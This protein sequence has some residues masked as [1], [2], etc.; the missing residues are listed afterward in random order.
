MKPRFALDLSHDAVSLLERT[1]DG[2]VR[3]GNALLDAPSLGDQLGGMKALAHARAPEGFVSKLILPNTQILYFEM[4]APGEDQATRRARIEEAL[5]GRTPYA[6]EDLVY[7]FSRQG[8]HVK[9]AVVARETLEEAEGFAEAYGF[10]PAAFV[11]IPEASRFAGEP[12]FGLT[13][14]ANHYLPKDTRF[15][16][17]QDPARVIAQAVAPLAALFRALPGLADAP[18]LDASVSSSGP[19]TLVVPG[20]TEADTMP[21]GNTP[22]AADPGESRSPLETSSDG[23]TDGVILGGAAPSTEVG[24]PANAAPLPDKVE[25]P[26]DPTLPGT[27]AQT[28]SPLAAADLT[29]DADADADAPHPAEP[30]LAPGASAVMEPDLQPEASQV[31][32]AAAPP[33][34]AV[35]EDYEAPFVDV[36]DADMADPA[37]NTDLAGPPQQRNEPAAF[38]SRRT[39]HP[40]DE[41]QDEPGARLAAIIPR[42]GGI[43]AQKPGDASLG[44]AAPIVGAPARPNAALQ[45]Q[46]SRLSFADTDAGLRSV[47]PARKPSVEARPA[48]DQ[49]AQRA[50]TA[51]AA[52]AFVFDG[53]RLIN[54]G[55]LTS[56]PALLAAA[57]L[58]LVGAIGLSA[59]FLGTTNDP[60]AADPNALPAPE[61]TV[62]ETTAPPSTDTSQIDLPRPAADV[63]VPAAIAEPAPDADIGSVTTESAGPEPLGIDNALPQTAALLTDPPLAAQPQ[64]QP[65]GTLL[66]FDEMGR[67]AAT[68]EGVVTPDG[69]TLYAGQ[70]PRLPPTR[71][72]HAEPAAA[73]NPLAGKRPRPRPADLVPVAAPAVESAPTQTTANLSDLPPLAPPVDPRHA[74]LKP[75]AR[76]VDFLAKVEAKRQADA[77]VADAAA[78]AARAEA[79]AAA[80]ALATASQLAVA[81]SRQPAPRSAVASAAAKKAELAVDDTALQVDSNAVD[82]ALAE[83][84]TTAEPEPAKAEVD[85]PEPQEGIANLPTTRTVAKKS[86][87]ANAIDLGDINLIGVYGSSSNRR[88]LVRMPNGRF[89]KVQVGD[90]FD[91]GQVAAIG[92]N[93][94]RYV[95]RGKTYAL[96]MVNDG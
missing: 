29:A 80:K 60:V 46:K 37:Q 30:D 63:Q 28:E 53:V 31:S 79:E 96:K 12:F 75:K 36:S 41:V 68:P 51:R 74:A 39:H 84:Q 33:P 61:G 88:A 42:L 78:S 22:A 34:D 54:A 81:T 93:E 43:R 67:I 9:V 58:L 66:R 65:F 92:D 59:I 27:F 1:A 35:A 25:P 57:A 89:L 26:L 24:F 4:D 32:T 48:P 15:D 56:R 73:P 2:W 83:A 19:T 11:A 47:S 69:F 40:A 94:L 91:G 52:K 76:S 3:I 87:L 44:H 49:N 23:E 7:D 90:N 10:H 5:A 72:A 86:T 6:V 70:P 14:V 71:A 21:P 77:A 95:K 50:S 82:A 16:R 64:P 55:P 13:T 45:M 38:H 8:D 20:N 62:P 17:D 18:A 85:E